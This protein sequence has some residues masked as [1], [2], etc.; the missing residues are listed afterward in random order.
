MPDGFIQRRNAAAQ[1]ISDRAVTLDLAL[2]KSDLS[3]QVFAI[4]LASF[5]LFVKR[6]VIHIQLDIPFLDCVVVTTLLLAPLPQL[7]LF[8]L[9]VVDLLLEL[10]YARVF[11]RQGFIQLGRGHLRFR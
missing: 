11:V 4:L 5:Q 2:K 1:L 7:V 3:P 10:F 8:F 9:D 6:L